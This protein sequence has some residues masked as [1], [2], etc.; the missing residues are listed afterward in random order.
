MRE[1][2]TGIG[3]LPFRKPGIFTL[4]ARSEAAC[5]TAWWT[6]SLGT[7]TVS[8]TLLS[9]SSSTWALIRPLD[10]T[11]YSLGLVQLYIIARH[12]ESSLNFENK[13]NGEPS[14]PVAL[15]QKGR[16]EAHLLGQQIAH[17]PIELCVV[18]RF[19]RT[20]ETAEI[21]LERREVP[22]EVEPLFDDIDVGELEGTTLEEYRAWK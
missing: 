2:R 17:I 11:A 20:R 12:G 5:S 14:V 10:Q 15:T 8:R 4:A 9:G 16:D 18:T 13:I 1:T 19:A 22:F 7:S 6:S 21:A 3:T